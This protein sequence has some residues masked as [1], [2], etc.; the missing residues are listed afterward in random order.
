MRPKCS[1]LDLFQVHLGL[2]DRRELEG[3][4]EYF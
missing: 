1:L 4:W 3:G 2:C